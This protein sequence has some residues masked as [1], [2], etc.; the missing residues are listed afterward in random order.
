MAAGAEIETADGYIHP[1]VNG[2]NILVKLL[3]QT[4]GYLLLQSALKYK[5]KVSQ[6]S[7]QRKTRQENCLM[8]MFL[9]QLKFSLPMLLT[10]HL[11]GPRSN[12]FFPSTH[13]PLL[14]IVNPHQHTPLHSAVVLHN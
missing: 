6:E 9:E 10:L 13:P 3:F 12:S 7:E 5:L 4:S 2:E 14:T 8:G 11:I 1:G